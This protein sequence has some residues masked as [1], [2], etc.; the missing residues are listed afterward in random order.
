MPD[1]IRPNLRI[2]R[3]SELSGQ[4][5]LGRGAGGIMAGQFVGFYWTLPVNWASFRSL[6]DDV[7][8]AAVASR[9]IRYQ[10]ERVRRWV[11]EERGKLIDE[12]VL[13]DVQPDRATDIVRSVLRQKL[14]RH[15]GKATLVAVAFHEA[16]GWRNNP[17]IQYAANDLNLDVMPLSPDPLQIDGKDF[18]PIRHFKR[19][20]EQDWAAKTQLRYEAVEGLRKALEQVPAGEGRWR[21][22]AALLNADGIKTIQGG[23][24]SPEN[25]RKLAGRLE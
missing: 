18:D 13:M 10:R 24:W 12:V 7:E 11:A 16:H 17:Y 20:R 23:Q 25:V 2:V 5:S 3:S 15:A 9:T 14:A 1:R 6:P 8:A 21:N 19:W 4:P 22:I